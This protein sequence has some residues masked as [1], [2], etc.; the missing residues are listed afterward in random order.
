MQK[1]ILPALMPLLLLIN[2]CGGGGAATEEAKPPVASE[3]QSADPVYVLPADEDIAAKV[4][5]PDYSVPND[6]F[7][8]ERASSGSS[9]TV[10][11]VMDESG[12]YERC[13]DSFETAQA[14]EESD[15]SA[16]AVQGYYVG[17]YENDRYFEFIRELAYDND[18]GNVGEPT[19]PGY[20]RIFKCANTSRD[21]VDRSEL[22]GY[23]GRLNVTPRSASDV[24]VFAEYLWQFTFFPYRH[25]KV[26][27][28]FAASSPNSH[29]QTLVLAFAINQGT[30]RCDRIEVVNWVFNADRARGEVS[31]SFDVIHT[32]EARLDNGSPELC[33]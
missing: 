14:W 17:A 11:H 28:S 31:Q 16:R 5:N 15:N 30:G 22:N 23:A 3:P 18:I 8:D 20:A 33:Q 7:V 26:L 4:Y 32:F 1:R 9:Y 24:R 10:Y 13:T 27:D 25:K 12:S 29:E 19:S 2:G 21:G 6:F